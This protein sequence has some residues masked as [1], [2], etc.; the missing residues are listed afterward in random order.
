VLIRF[1]MEREL[2]SPLLQWRYNG[3]AAGIGTGRNVL[4]VDPRLLARQ[5]H[6]RRHSD[7]AAGQEG[8]VNHENH[9][10]TYPHQFSR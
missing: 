4:A 10:Q 3:R 7:A 1:D 8:E 9:K 5:S 6:P 2:I